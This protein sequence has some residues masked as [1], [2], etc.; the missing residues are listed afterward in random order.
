MRRFG[1][2]LNAAPRPVTF[3]EAPMIGRKV[4]RFRVLAKLGEGGMA[5]VWRAEDELLGRDVALKVLQGP[6]ADHPKSR[7]RFRHEGESQM[8][9]HHPS[10]AEII[11][12]GEADDLAYIA[13]TLIDGPTVS[14]RAARSL[15]PIGEV[16]A[17]A[18]EVAAA[19]RHAHAEGVIHR[20]ITGRNIMLQ[21]DGHAL[22][23]D[24]G[25]ALSTG[26]TRL[27]TTGK[28]VGTFAYLAP[29]VIV[30]GHGDERS[31]LYALGVVMYEALTGRLPFVAERQE[32]LAYAIP[33]LPVESPRAL[34]PEIPEAV[35]A[36]VLKA[37]ARDPVERFA[38]AA[39]MLA[40]LECCAGSA[41]AEAETAAP[42][43]RGAGVLERLGPIYLGI[44][45]FDAPAGNGPPPPVAAALRRALEARLAGVPGVRVVTSG[46]P[47]AADATDW[48]ALARGM[49]ANLL[50]A[51]EVRA[52]EA[53]T[54]IIYGLIDPEQG[55]RLAGASV[56]GATA[57]P[58][59]LEDRLLERVTASLGLPAESAPPAGPRRDP[60]AEEHFRQ[61]LRY[62]DRFDQEGSV[63]AAIQILE[64]LVEGEGHDARYPA[65]LARAFLHK[66]GHSAA[67][68]WQ[69]RAATAY[70]KAAAIDAER[71]DVRLALA[72]LQSS[73]GRSESALAIYRD[74]LTEEHD[75]L[76]GYV[77]AAIRLGAAGEAE[78]ACRKAI[79]ERPSDWQA[80][81]LLGLA[82]ASRGDYRGALA[83][84]RRVRRLAPGNV[85]VYRN[86]GAALFYMGRLERAVPFY[87]ESAALLPNARAYA[88]LG[89]ILFFLG[90]RAECLEALERAVALAPADPEFLGNLGSACRQIP[91]QE[92]RAAE[93]LDR[94]IALVSERLRRAPDDAWSRARLGGWLAN[95]GRFAE[96]I[97]AAEHALRL[98]PG[99][100]ECMLR[101]G[102]VFLHAGE[103]EMAL[104]WFREAVRHGRGVV[105]LERDPELES[106][107]KDPEFRSILAL[108]R[109]SRSD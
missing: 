77:R 75:A 48:R 35:S 89:S 4:G 68:I 13:M 31:D 12:A 9:L 70:A 65:A 71:S 27:T 34:R 22:I 33:N 103:R 107:R 46:A 52:T 28:V 84:W 20:D 11:E 7:R 5:A 39:E 109:P 90:R 24:F 36:V 82:Q 101:A 26:A 100:N 21:K 17:M 30:G 93:A 15:M 83:A 58:F 106:L 57:D 66:Y 23:V 69:D 88:N 38:D 29:E 18:K 62:L 32:Q 14:E 104:H 49:G 60:A 102:Y 64:R 108:G 97:A 81:N 91:G 42:G 78:Q 105:E 1:P 2:P 10:I 8:R 96:A 80:H 6:A 99:E 37:M 3:S 54:R 47:V 19:L 98:A 85:L 51:G 43:A 74:L 16:L 55:V 73:T 40:A 53:M 63:D 94:A 45:G 76:R 79:R 67:R 25:L 44:V 50:L 59:E 95:R 86:I 92:V 61:A 41:R 87:R 56:D 72:D